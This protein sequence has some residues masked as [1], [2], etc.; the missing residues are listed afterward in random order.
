ML[1]PYQYNVVK[2]EITNL[3]NIYKTVN[4]KQVVKTSQA[5]ATSKIEPLLGKELHEL[6]YSDYMDVKLTNARAVKIYDK[7]KAHV[8]PFPTISSKQIEKSFRKVKK[9]KYPKIEE[10][11][12]KETTYLA[13]DD[14]GT[15]RKYINFFYED[16]LVGMYGVMSPQVIKNVC[17]IC[18]SI[19][20]VAMFLS[21][22]K[23]S[24]D[25]TYTKKG[26]YVCT[27]SC[28]CNRQL[29]SLDHLY[30]FYQTLSK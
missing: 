24:G 8:A 7:L 1:Q 20:N 23:S 9:L 10:Y 2:Q 29:T 22:T 27:D 13:W 26:N 21:T 16:K 3:I 19:G 17:S 6:I 28:N 30:D 5:V 14:I 25:G 15:Q 18:H 4:D 12:L 11:D